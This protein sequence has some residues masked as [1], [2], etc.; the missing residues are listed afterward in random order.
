MSEPVD[1]WALSDLRTPWCLHV[2][3]TLRIA[4]QIAVGVHG[5]DQLAEAA[6]CD[7]YALQRI[8][9]TLV[10]KGVFE[11]P[12]P[13]QFHLNETAETLLD[14]GV[15]LGLD[16]NGIGGRM[17][18]A[19]SSLLKYARTGKPAYQDIFG[20][21]FW[22]DLEAHPEVAE[23]FDAM[24]G[25][26]G[27]GWPDADFDIDGGWEAVRSVVD[28]GGGTGAFLAE[29]LRQHASLH[30]TL[31]DLPKTVA[32]AEGNFQAA[33]VAARVRLVGQSFFDPLPAGADLY[34][35]RGIINDW[36]D[37][38]AVQI[39]ARCREAAH[40]HGRVVV[41]KGF[42]AED[43]PEGLMIEMVLL[44]GR[45]RTVSAFRAL[46]QQAGLAVTSAGRQRAGYI[47]V[48]C[49]PLQAPGL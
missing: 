2:A 28:V 34:L 43:A 41:L 49:R 3:V 6:N 19:W 27:H 48:E 23:S 37:R 46:A 38:E 40:P 47:A 24:I 9:T 35:L 45:M 13:G 1:L 20:L 33:G 15:R 7:A 44:G 31:V 42:E 25:P 17:A 12:A 26:L 5:V 18:H 4:E 29:V 22:E 11:Q 14:T 32:R 8:L 21:P 30:G 36:P 39:L 10:E 16:L